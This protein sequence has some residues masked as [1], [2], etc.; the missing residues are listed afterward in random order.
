MLLRPDR[1]R[2]AKTRW[3]R[4]MRR[5]WMMVVK[6]NR[7]RFRIPESSEK[8]RPDVESERGRNSPERRAR[9]EGT[10]SHNTWNL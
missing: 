3:L 4:G 9:Y 10:R 6:K 7:K 8:P 1:V 2:S 5:P